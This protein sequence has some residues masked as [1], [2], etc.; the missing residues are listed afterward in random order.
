MCPCAL[1]SVT[2]ARAAAAVDISLRIPSLLFFPHPVVLTLPSP[3][4]VVLF[5]ATCPFQFLAMPARWPHLKPPA[6]FPKSLASPHLG[7]A[8]PPARFQ[9]RAVGLHAES[10]CR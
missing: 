6:F 7:F 4:W 3:S 5:A 8:L 2:V 1:G 9:S 10:S